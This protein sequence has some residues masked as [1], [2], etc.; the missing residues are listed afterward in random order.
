MIPVL[1]E[2]ET[3]NFISGGQWVAP[4]GFLSDCI[5]CEMT[6]ERN[7]KY[8]VVFEYPAAGVSASDI[9][10]NALIGISVPAK[11]GRNPLQVFRVYD[12]VHTFDGHMTVYAQH[13]SYIY[14][15]TPWFNKAAGGGM[16]DTSFQSNVTGV[17]A[18]VNKLN[19]NLA[20][21]NDTFTSV[22]ITSDITTT[23]STAQ[24]Y[25]PADLRSIR[26]CIGGQVG[27]LLDLFGGELEWDNLDHVYLNAARG[28]DRDYY[29]EYGVNIID[30]SMEQ[31]IAECYTGVV[32]TW[33]YTNPETN[34]TWE[35][36]AVK[37]AANASSFAVKRWYV[38]DCTGNENLTGM[39]PDTTANINSIKAK[40]QGLT[41]VK[42][43]E[44]QVGVP[45]VSIDVNF[46]DLLGTEEYKNIRSL[47]QFYLCDSVMVNIPRYGVDE[48]A[49]ITS[50]VYDVLRERY[51]GMHIG[52]AAV[53]TLADTLSVSG[54]VTN[55][56]NAVINEP[57]VAGSN[58][59]ITDY[60]ISAPDVLHTAAAKYKTLTPTVNTTY[61]DSSTS[62]TVKAW[63]CG[64]IVFV[65]FW[66]TK[67]TTNPGGN[68]VV[69]GLPGTVGNAS[70]DAYL[71][72]GSSSFASIGGQLYAAYAGGI[73][74]NISRTNTALYGVLIYVTSN[75]PT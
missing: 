36:Y 68:Y 56:N 44:I 58:I 60:V 41:N 31:N 34:N 23:L 40:L 69:T 70:G 67:F 6:E 11:T 53:S 45:R 38:Y 72:L 25:P 16:W 71:H 62:G 17:T 74:C 66:G 26:N 57:Y 27:S 51:I 14:A 61:I 42:A 7:G 21:Y 1:F 18:A 28:E 15:Q 48:R 8:E 39:I 43:N 24:K 4:L 52:D 64:C 37:E 5:S 55:V 49:K 46:A 33:R 59:D 2:P 63:Q 20:A 22:P 73:S 75:Y 50:V 19:A 32:A 47:Q 29:V 9:V 3:I 65:S 13:I 54:G 35:C 30:A 12:I 10:V